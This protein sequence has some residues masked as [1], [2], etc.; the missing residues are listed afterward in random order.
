M[1]AVVTGTLVRDP[2]RI[3]EDKGA[4][5]SVASNEA[6]RDKDGEAQEYANFFD[7]VVWGKASVPVMQFLAQGS[8]VTID[9]RLK[10]ER[11]KNDQDQTRSKVTIH[12]QSVLFGDKKGEGSGGSSGADSAPASDDDED[13][14]F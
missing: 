4:R 3:G 13:I 11:W 5:F 2:E 6:W 8:R 9:G 1:R 14:P 12:A 7:V 10:Q